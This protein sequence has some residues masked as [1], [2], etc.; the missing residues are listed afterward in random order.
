MP[1]LSELSVGKYRSPMRRA[2]HPGWLAA[3]W[4]EKLPLARVY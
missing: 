4:S 3:S 2:P 1:G